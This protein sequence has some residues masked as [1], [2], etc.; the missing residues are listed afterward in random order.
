MTQFS[1]IG[2]KVPRIDAGQIIT[3]V[4]Q[5]SVDITLPGMLTGHILRSHVPHARIRSINV[6]K[7]RALPGVLAV[8][9]GEDTLQRKY[10]YRESSADEYGLAVGK[11]RY[12]GEQVAAVAALD[13]D[14]AEEALSLIE[15]DYEILPAVFDPQ[16]ARQEGAPLVHD[17]VPGNVSYA[18]RF[19]WGNVEK[20]F[21]ESDYIRED[22]FTTQPQIHCSMEPHA[23]VAQFAGGQLTVWS[24]TQGPYALR[25]ELALTLGFPEGKIRVVK[26]RM[27]GGFGGKREMFA[28]DFCAALLSMKTG[29]PVKIVYSR[30]EE[31]IASRQRHPM[32]ITLKTGYSKDGRI[33][34]KDCTLVAD[35]GAYNSRGPGILSY[36]GASLASLYRIPHVRYAGYHVYTNKPVGGAFRGYGSLQVR[37]ADESQMDMI[38]EELGMDP[39]ELRLK[40]VVASGDTTVSGRKITSC[41]I[42]ECLQKVAEASGWSEKRLMKKK[43]FGIGMACNDYVSALRSIY[44]YDSSSALVRPNEDGSVDVYTGA[45]DIGQG[46]DTAIAQIVAEELT[47]PVEKINIISADTQT[48]VMDLGSYA[49]RVTFVAGNAAKKAAEDL[50]EQLFNHLSGY[51]ATDKGNLCC[52]GGSICVAGRDDLSLTMAEAVCRV[53]NKEGKFLL[54]RGYY[55]APSEAVDYRT[56]YGNSS[57][58][59][60]YGAQVAEVKV[61]FK[62]GRVQVIRVV[63]ASDCGRVI[64]PLG[65]EGQA[66]GAVVCGLGMTLLEDRLTEE[67]Q[68]LNPSFLEYKIPTASEAPVIESYA[69]ETIDP[70]GPFGAKG[71]S[72][73]YQVPTAPAI[74]NAIYDAIGIRFHKL[75]VTSEDVWRALRQ[76]KEEDAP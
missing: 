57:P 62:T 73:G 63:D 10:G 4:A 1:A 15:V 18:P 20:G 69:V 2:H 14:L 28:S 49:S 72:E 36:A 35:G 48:G 21:A 55:D 11:V 51:W 71:V 30:T 65:L 54:G 24:T 42:K 34:A 66:E 41:G 61:D 17:G 33:I 59:Y 37:F 74:V 70:E 44:E 58:A 3:G 19:H 60:S 26:P 12:A 68:T 50:K 27:G 47:V 31:F 29:R 53:L 5:Y 40:N 7:A 43:G 32:F 76:G 38:A 16:E 52:Q 23:A 6:E 9:T 8:V 13:K 64:N 75:P 22:A 46:S 56:G 45:S 39:L 25:K 67:G